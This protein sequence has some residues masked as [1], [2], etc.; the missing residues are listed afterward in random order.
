[1]K[2]VKG[3]SAGGSQAETSTTAEECNKRRQCG[4]KNKIT[5]I[6]LIGCHVL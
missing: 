6:M 5:L 1:M 3:T 4:N 2:A